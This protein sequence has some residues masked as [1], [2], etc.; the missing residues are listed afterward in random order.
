MVEGANCQQKLSL[1]HNIQHKRGR[2]IEEYPKEGG[3]KWAFGMK[4]YHN[5]LSNS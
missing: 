2:C 3:Y 1:G 5:F 4:A